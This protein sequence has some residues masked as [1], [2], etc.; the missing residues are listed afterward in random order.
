MGNDFGNMRV[1]LRR[2]FIVGAILAAV[3]AVLFVSVGCVSK[4]DEKQS[5]EP[6]YR[7]NI[8]YQLSRSK[9]TLLY[10]VFMLDHDHWPKV[11]RVA[12]SRFG[13]GF[14]F[15]GVGERRYR[16]WSFGI[17]PH[18]FE[19]FAAL[20]HDKVRFT[21]IKSSWKPKEEPYLLY[22]TA[23]YSQPSLSIL[24]HAVYSDVTDEVRPL[25]EQLRSWQQS[26]RKVWATPPDPEQ[27]PPTIG[28]LE[29]D[30]IEFLEHMMNSLHYTS[31]W[32]REK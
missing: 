15:E 19:Q 20:L 18:Q 23:G 31:T 21:S 10:A 9:E 26:A 27:G 22:M 4:R 3:I 29:T 32:R 16:L 2:V 11:T 7:I 13:F 25:M 17:S 24:T 12:I 14:V 28:T 8:D 6:S 5:T 1:H 30:D